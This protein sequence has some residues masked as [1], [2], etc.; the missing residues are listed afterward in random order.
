MFFVLTDI[1]RIANPVRSSPFG[2]EGGGRFSN[3][4]GNIIPT[5]I[6]IYYIDYFSLNLPRNIYYSSRN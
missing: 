2:S 3:M 6:L 5:P 4:H 1:A